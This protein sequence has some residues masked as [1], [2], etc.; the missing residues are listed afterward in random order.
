MFPCEFCGI[1]KKTFF[2]KHL[3]TTA[4]E[5]AKKQATLLKKRLWHKCF[6]VNF[7]EFLGSKSCKTPLKFLRKKVFKLHIFFWGGYRLETFLLV[8]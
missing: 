5:V 3:W 1:S 2:T 4:S 6:P 8:T 7:V